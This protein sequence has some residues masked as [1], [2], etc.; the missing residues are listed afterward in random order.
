VKIHSRFDVSDLEL[1]ADES[2]SVEQVSAAIMRLADR[3]KMQVTR[4][5]ALARSKLAWKGEVFQQAILHRL[6]ALASGAVLDWNERNMLGSFLAA[7]ALVETVA[8]IADVAGTL[9]GLIAASDLQGIDRLI[10]NRTFATRDEV[11]LAESPES[12]AVNVLT[13][14]DKLDA[15]G[16]PGVREHYDRMSE[17]C[18]PNAMGHHQLFSATDKETATVTFD[19]N[20]HRDRNFQTIFGAVFLVRIVESSFNSLDESIAAVAALQHKMKPV[21]K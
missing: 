17:R 21:G 16:L 14:I 10:M 15:T 9:P 4:S 11:I 8:V 3:R 7:R 12:K 13:L 20:K 5:G 6:V 1:D 2:D 18:H 19:T